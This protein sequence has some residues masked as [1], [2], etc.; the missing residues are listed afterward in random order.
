MNHTR[1]VLETPIRIGPF[2]VSELIGRG[3]MG[4]VWKGI[5]AEQG[6][7]VAMKV[8][9]GHLSTR[10]T[11][12]ANFREEV[13]KVA[14]FNHPGIVIVFDNGEIPLEASRECR[15]QLGSAMED[16]LE[17]G[18]PYLVMEYC[19]GGSLRERMKV[20]NW[21]DIRRLL[22]SLLDALA[23]AHARG[24][25]HR[26]LK[27]DNVLFTSGPDAMPVVKLTDFGVSLSADIGSTTMENRIVGTLPFMAPEQF[28]DWR[29]QG[30][31]T[32]L[33]ALGCMAYQLASGSPP[34]SGR[35][36]AE[37]AGQHMF[38]EPPPLS[39]PSSFPPEYAG[40]V[41]RL[42]EKKPQDRFRCAADAAYA[43]A[44]L[45]GREQPSTSEFTSEMT[46]LVLHEPTQPL[47]GDGW[48]QFGRSFPD[49]EQPPATAAQTVEVL[50]PRPA[51]IPDTWHS[52][53]PPKATMSLI[54]TG[55]GLY[56]WRTVPLV[57]RLDQRDH[58]W[59]RL[60][61]VHRHGRAHALLLRGEA[62][63][64]K[65]RLARWMG[66]RSMEVG[67][68]T[69]LLRAEHNPIPGPRHG[70]PPMVAGH[71]RCFGLGQESVQRRVD[72]V[73]ALHGITDRYDRLAL[74]D[75]I[76]GDY[77][78][79]A[80][81]P[82]E[83]HI[84]FRRFVE[85]LCKE[86]TVV[87]VLEDVQWG[88]D[89]LGFVQHILDSQDEQ[90]I[91]L[92][93][94]MTAREEILQRRPLELELVRELCSHGASEDREI[95][96]LAGEDQEQLVRQLL[97][98]EGPL[99]NQVR[100]RTGGNPLFAVQLV[101]DWISRG[102][103]R[104]GRTGFVLASGEKA[105]VPST[106]Y[107]MW[108]ARLSRVLANQPEE[109]ERALQVAAALGLEV[110]RSEWQSAC[111]ALGIEFSMGVVEALLAD[112]LAEPR[113][114]GWAFSHG[115]LRESIQQ[116]AVEAGFWTRV[117]RACA[118]MLRETPEILGRME[119]IGQHLVEA[120]E[121]EQ[122]LEPLMLGAQERLDTSDY[123]KASELLDRRE[124]IMR[125]L[126]VSSRDERW[127]QSWI[128]R[129]RAQLG[130]GEFKDA[131][132]LAAQTAEKARRN[133]WKG[134]YPGALRFQAMT[135]WKQGD[136]G[137][138]ETVLVR[139][140]MEA[141]RAG[142]R[143]EE[144]RSILNLSIVNRMLGDPDRALENSR[145]AHAIFKELNQRLGM[146]D[147]LTEIGNNH[148]A[149]GQ[150]DEGG[151]HLRRALQLFQAI[152][153]Q[154]GIAHTHNSLAEI[155]RQQEKLPEAEQE[156]ENAEE[157]LARVGSP[158]RIVP[159]ANRGLI[160]LKQGE[161][162]R[163]QRTLDEALSSAVLAKQRH[164][165]AYLHVALLSCH[166]H[167]LA[168]PSWDDHLENAKELLAET[169]AV[170]KDIAWP[171]ELAARI[172]TDAGEKQRAIEAL[173]IAQEQWQ[174]LRN[175]DMAERI[176]DIIRESQEI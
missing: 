113:D 159:K 116:D 176:E 122:S 21:S 2:L 62:G 19:G 7:A 32:D 72:K 119:R 121:L 145:Q 41:L 66:E 164:L 28:E 126:D 127:G 117:N 69:T 150:L 47:S 100:D 103:L 42:L 63:V 46:T 14:Q 114:N 33:Y 94:L 45:V 141:M 71:L 65:S 68:V 147:G 151:D 133:R 57:D 131:G 50:P 148:M 77:Q 56:Q 143:L 96:P 111:R 81:T 15:E 8:L 89:T 102:V 88:S 155:L 171:A 44:A 26:D 140:Q 64:G 80:P 9:S 153:N 1:T 37:F 38:S 146:A 161:Y 60:I 157:M 136:L 138:A 53:A 40:W 129:I 82:A 17:P 95:G 91:P 106:I 162:G 86:R 58:I 18:G 51:P 115:M 34:F 29:D 134:I 160:L 11:H 54:G 20:L 27:P 92:L 139:A 75:F 74:A 167:A 85:L 166:A 128:G 48:K 168:W 35:G 107:A 144:A 158:E 22:L 118:E 24:V 137:L 120:Q 76:V 49:A 105:A 36:A 124:E 163:A 156:Y 132:H 10:Q 70:I 98:L 99:A 152:G 39:L 135:L 87:L 175:E 67:A 109:T 169:G 93:I 110:D 13:R 25:I 174:A 112:H 4:V 73:L 43:L 149:M 104:V 83:R 108:Q 55:M 154:F 142:D 59:K 3:G 170:D 5:H 31:W 173:R 61:D 165:Q 130:L 84:V 52:K 97:R 78:D 30:P 23:H 12:L 79:V 123:R 101:G 172:A 90:P 16:R 6:V 125:T